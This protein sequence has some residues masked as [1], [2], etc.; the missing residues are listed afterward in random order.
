MEDMRLGGLV[1]LSPDKISSLLIRIIGP[2]LLIVLFMLVSFMTFTYFTEILPYLIPM[3]GPWNGLFLTI[4][5]LSI[6][7]NI[8]YNYFYCVTRG[9]G[10]PPDNQ[11]LPKCRTCKGP[12]PKR[13]HHCSICNKCVLKMDH[14]CPWI[15]NCVGHSNHR[16]FL[17]FLV[18]LTIGCL[19]IAIVSYS[20]FN[21]KPRNGSVHLCFLLSVVFSFV[22]FFFTAWHMFL[23]L[24]GFT[25]IELFG[26]YGD[27]DKNKYNFSRGTW[28]KN[29]ES[30]FGTSNLLYALMPSSLPLPF[31]GVN[32]P[33]TIHAI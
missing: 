8:L 25:T 18:Y 6:L 23:I 22:L 5:G 2:F 27:E 17:L 21:T 28:R 11:D 32:W 20:R 7:F 31:D 30:V 26:Y 33:D 10:H 16:Y 9:P 4:F 12:K 19:F 24:S 3:L 13:A 15:M 29:L 1:K 14:H